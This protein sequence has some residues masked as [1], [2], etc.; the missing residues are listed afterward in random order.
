MT[1]TWA[2]FIGEP[3]RFGLPPS[4]PFGFEEDQ[5]RA[6]PVR[7]PFTFQPCSDET[8]SA[9]SNSRQNGFLESHCL[10]SNRQPARVVCR[11]IGR[12]LVMRRT[13]KIR[14]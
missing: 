8:D 13:A 4:R 12:H 9:D 1:T 14:I 7:Q 11:A 6:L 10:V 2:C 3:D 5:R